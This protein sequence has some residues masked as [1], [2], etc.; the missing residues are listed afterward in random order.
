MGVIDLATQTTKGIRNT[1]TL[2]DNKVTTRK[3]LPRYFGPE[4]VL[5][6]CVINLFITFSAFQR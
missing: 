3:R 2:F 1:A 5:E 4:G 6:V